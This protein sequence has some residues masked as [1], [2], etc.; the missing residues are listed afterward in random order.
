MA[1]FEKR[2]SGWRVKIRICGVS[3]SESFKTKAE[4]V[5]WAAARE[6]EIRA[7]GR[8]RV[9]AITVRQL[10]ER[11]LRE[12]T[13]NKLGARPEAYRLRR[14]LGLPSSDG[15]DER[16]ADPL[17]DVL[18]PDLTPAHIVA[19]RDR[20][21]EKVAV[22]S[23]LRELNSISAVFNHAV[24]VWHMLHVNPCHAMVRPPEPLSRTQVY[25]QAEIDR[26]TLSSGYREDEPPVTTT[27][28]VGAAFLFALESAMRQAEIARLTPDRV[29]LARRVAYLDEVDERQEGRF[30]TKNG[31]ARVVPLTSKA[32]RIIEQML[33]LVKDGGPIFGMAEGT[34]S[35]LFRK[36][37]E[38]A[39]VE[40]KTF[41]DA[42]RTALTALAKKVDVMT[43]AKISGHR[44]LKELLNTYYQ[45]DMAEVAARLD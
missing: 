7:T 5:A 18:L 37:R 1:T 8:G 19:W 35:T 26:I 16:E 15:G 39:M 24:K 42:R 22:G 20:R 29:D 21:L 23:V 45:P 43:L 4:A 11:Y 17:A 38:R 9:A 41:H 33:P 14:V 32:I 36:I 44:N 28:K 6:T 40:G 34:M 25:D 30:R 2:S 12:V 27:A 31:D 13:P 3:E 10:F